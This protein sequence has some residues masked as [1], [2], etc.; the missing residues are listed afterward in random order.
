VPDPGLGSIPSIA[1][2]HEKRANIETLFVGATDFALVWLSAAL[3]LRFRLDAG[4]ISYG[5]SLVKNAGFLVLLSILTVL[6][7]HTQRLYETRVR[8]V[9]AEAIAVVKAVAFATIVIS[10]SIYLSGQAVVSRIALGLTVVTSATLLVSWRNI[11]RIHMMKRVSAGQ[12]CR[13]VVIV[14]WSARAQLL[15]QHFVQNRMLGYV[16]KGFL[17]RR[18]RRGQVTDIALAKHPPK[19]SSKPIGHLDDIFNVVRTHFIDEVWVLLPEERERVMQL[20]AQSRALG[21]NLRVIPDLYDGLALRPSIEYLGPFA[22][23][24]IHEKPIPYLGLIFKRCVDVIGSSLALL[25]CLPLGLLIALAIR[26]DSP[27]PLLYCSKRVGKKGAIFT[28]YKFRT[29]VQNADA[30]KASLH[31]RNERS[32]VLFKIADDPR[33][34]RVGQILRKY[35]LDELP[36]LWNVLNGDMSLVGPRPPI[37]GEYVQYELE[38]LKRLQVPPGITGLWQV[39][40]RTNPSFESYI[41]LDSHY[42]DNWSVW[43]DLKILFRTVGVVFGGTGQ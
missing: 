15:E 34:T 1:T 6:F 29:M 32:G 7:C 37:P 20:I 10:A 42:V 40:A 21:V 2:I 43:L 13:N 27:G 12:D 16:V 30:L 18:R 11:W 14:G 36:Q 4:A 5:A 35:S 28:C 3:A 31:H 26:F 23:L 22:A 8:S 9:L 38:H 41:S 25:F 39:E 17:D 19:P 24:N 33:I